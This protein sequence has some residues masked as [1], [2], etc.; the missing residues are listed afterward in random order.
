MK[1]RIGDGEPFITSRSNTSPAMMKGLITAAS[2]AALVV[3]TDEE[4][5]TIGLYARPVVMSISTLSDHMPD[6]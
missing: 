1:H 5:S 4:I 3:M 6:Q 2:Y